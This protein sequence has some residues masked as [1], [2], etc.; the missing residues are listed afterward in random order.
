MPNSKTRKPT[1]WETVHEWYDRAV[2]EEGHYYHQ[3][4]IL[5]KTLNLLGA[6]KSV[7]DIGCGQG[8]F[9]RK[10]PKQI[11]YAG[12]DISPSLIS[13]AKALTP[14][15]KDCFFVHDAEEPLP[16]KGHSHAVL[17]LALQNMAN[18]QAVLKNIYDAL[19]KQGSLIVVLNHPCFRIPRLSG[20]HI[21][22]KKKLQSRRIDS[23]MSSIEIPIQANPSQGNQSSQSLSFHHSLSYFAKILH[24]ARFSITL[25][26]EWCSDKTSTGSAARMENRARKEFPLFLAIVAQ[27]L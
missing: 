5:P 12:I 18:P 17:I 3:N 2:G 11:G 10:C 23:Y 25:L 19:E 8:I 27:K 13:K 20:W 24:E 15:R 6:A 1:S 9:A 14:W 7:L 22:Q 16:C 4:I 26:E 21:E